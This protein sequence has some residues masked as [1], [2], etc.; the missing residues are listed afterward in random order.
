M[1]TNLLVVFCGALMLVAGC[2]S[3]VNDRHTFALS[4]G[5]DRI[6]SRY[7]RPVDQVFATAKEVVKDMGNLTREGT[8]YPDQNK[9][10]RTL[11]GKVNQRD[12]WIRIE[13]VDP[14]ITAVTVQ[15]RTSAGGTDLQLAAEIKERIAIA[16]TAGK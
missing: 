12:I 5:K 15:A 1:K 14:N 8:L 2:V 6:E 16:L 10:I 3:T 7:N 11:E 9:V 4:P 13:A